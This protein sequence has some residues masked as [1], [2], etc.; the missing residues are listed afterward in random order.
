MHA[1]AGFP[2]KSTWLKAIKNGTF[3][4]WPRLTYNNAAK[5]FPHSVETLK[6]H[7]VQ[8]TQGVR[9]KKKKK[10]H[11]NQKKPT[12]DTLQK[13]SEA[14]NIP[15]QKKTQELHIWDQPVSKLYTDDCRIFPIRSI[16]G[17]EYIMIAYHCD[18]NTILQPPF[19]N[20]K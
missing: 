10:T 18:P 14:A 1:A 20:R 2:V 9:S 13:Q 16:S 5:Y 3:E 7:M 8:Y 17:N 15:P 4:S 11:N 6:G 19:I 12:Q